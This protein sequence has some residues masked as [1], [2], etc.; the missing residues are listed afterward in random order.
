MLAS[1]SA[2]AVRCL[3]F[4]L[5][6]PTAPASLQAAN[7]PIQDADWAPT[8]SSYA[9]V[10]A[11]LPGGRPAHSHVRE[12][13]ELL[14]VLLD[15][16]HRCVGAGGESGGGKVVE[17]PAE[18][19]AARLVRYGGAQPCR[20]GTTPEADAQA[21]RGIAAATWRDRRSSRPRG[22]RT[23]PRHCLCFRA[24]LQARSKAA[25]TEAMETYA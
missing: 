4:L 11:R 22:E 13:H 23:P 19:I 7:T 3:R 8:L 14:G 16:V 10:L 24:G 9:L 21:S 6:F 15:A 12:A 20:I 18:C 1:V 5:P 25:M 17:R 2:S